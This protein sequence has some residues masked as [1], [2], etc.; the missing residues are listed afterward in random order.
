MTKQRSFR[1]TMILLLGL[2]MLASGAITYGVYKLLQAYYSGVRAEDPLA[3]YRHFMRNIGDIYFFLLLF[4]PLAILFFFWFT[5]P[6]AAYFRDISAGISHLANGDFQHRVQISSRDELGMIAEDVNLASEK[7]QQAIERG[8]FAENSKDQLVVNLAHDLRTPLTSVL[9]Y[10]DLLMKDDQLTE[11]Q[12][13]H[14]TTIAFTKSRRLEK[15]ID[16]LF[17]ITRMNY[18]MLTVQKTQLNLSEL[19]KQMNEEMYPVFE[20]N[21]L[22]TRVKL[23]ADLVVS[24]DGELLARVF[25]NLLMNA[26]RH[27]KDGVY[28]DIHG[29][30]EEDQIVIQVINYGGHIPPEDLPYIFDMY[31]TADRARTPQEGGTGLGL[32]IAR[33]IVEQHDGTISVQSNVVRTLFEVRLP[34]LS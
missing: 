16:N 11:E 9:G 34:A 7:L 2:S 8:D 32:F 12:V 1:T 23:D 33:N 17:E 30:R 21:H 4:I 15:L 6:Y 5:K 22:I 25:E 28:V 26:S 19:L 24:G 27:G 13:R 29:S 10:L 20:K 3:Q 31:Y 14:F 18:G